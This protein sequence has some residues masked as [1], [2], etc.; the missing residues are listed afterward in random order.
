MTAL[1]L[2]PQYTDEQ[3]RAA[4]RIYKLPTWP[5]T[6]EEAMADE[7]LSRLVRLHA[8]HMVHP[9]RAAAPTPCPRPA[10]G[11]QRHFTALPPGWV[12]HK[13]AAAGDRDD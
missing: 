6:F 5:A 13:R 9:R 10:I 11:A 4:W 3:L 12:D 1:S 7:L 2:K 8:S